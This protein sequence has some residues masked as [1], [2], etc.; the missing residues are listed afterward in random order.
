M[1]KNEKLPWSA[2]FTTR[3]RLNA[4]SGMTGHF[5]KKIETNTAST[6]LHAAAE[7]LQEL[8]LVIEAAPT[9]GDTRVAKRR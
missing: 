7:N 8:C 6:R 3:P 1:P 9:S 4:K 5:V 2:A